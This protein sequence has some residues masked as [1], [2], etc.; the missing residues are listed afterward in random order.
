MAN[1]LPGRAHLSSDEL[2]VDQLKKTKSYKRLFSCFLHPRKFYQNT[3]RLHKKK[4]CQMF[5]S[6]VNKKRFKHKMKT[7]IT[8]NLKNLD[9]DRETNLDFLELQKLNALYKN[10][11]RCGKNKQKYL[12]RNYIWNQTKYKNGHKFKIR[13]FMVVLSTKPM[14]VVFH[15]GYTILD[16]FNNS[17]SFTDASISHEDLFDFLKTEKGISKVRFN[18]IFEE[19]RQACSLLL[20]ITYRKFLR[21]ARYFQVFA[22]DFELDSEMT[23]W[24]VD[25]KGSPDYTLKNEKF[26]SDLLGIVDQMNQER[27][28]RIMNLVNEA[29]HA[30]NQSLKEGTLRAQYW[31]LFIPDLR[32]LVSEKMADLPSTLSNSLPSKKRLREAQMEILFDETRQGKAKGDIP[33]FCL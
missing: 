11:K 12:L 31:S 8:Y 7:Q 10:G 1:H 2:M 17:I 25:V 19:I 26:V 6:I 33:E 24:L 22:V 18:Y 28:Q 32:K 21:D 13:S 3:M 14:F 4:E 20:E 5:F 23:P 15:K 29:R 9:S 16:R 27:T 30:V